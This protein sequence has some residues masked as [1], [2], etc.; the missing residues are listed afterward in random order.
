[1]EVDVV[2]S[3]SKAIEIS[4]ETKVI[5]SLKTPDSALSTTSENSVQNKVITEELNKKVNKT[6]IATING[7]PLT[8]GGNIVIE[9]SGGSYDDTELKEQVA[10]LAEKTEKAEFLTEFYESIEDVEGRSEITLDSESRVIAFRDAEGTKV[11]ANLKVSHSFELADKAMQ[12]FHKALKESGF[13]VETPVDWSSEKTIKL[14]IPRSCAKV[15]IISVTGLAT[16]KTDNKVCILQYWDKD[17]NYFKKYVVLNA[18]G[19][20]SMSYIEK[21][22]GIDVFNDEAC[23]ESCDIIFGNWVAQDSFHLKCYYIDVFRGISNVGYNFSEEVI[24]FMNSRNNRLVL[25]DSSI[26]SS[27]S[28]G[29]FSIDFGDGALCHPDGFPFELYVNGEYYGL[30]AWNLKKHRK[31]YS[32]SKSDYS[33][34]LLDGTLGQKFF[35]GEIDWTAFELRNPKELVTMTGEEYDGENPSELMDETSSAYDANNPVHVNTA[36]AKALVV[37]QSQAPNLISALADT[38]TVEAQALFEQYYDK[39]AVICYFL[40][41]N[42]VFHYDGF[43]K[44]WIWTIYDQIAAPSF[45]DMDSIFGRH[46]NGTQVVSTSLTGILGNEEWHPTR[47]ALRLYWQEIKDTYKALRDAGIISVDNV[48]NHVKKWMDRVGLDAYAS[49][50]EKWDNIP[51]YRAEKTIEDGTAD[52]GFFDSSKRI[53]KWLVERL[54]K[55]DS[56]FAYGA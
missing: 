28:T 7:Q 43:N 19:T 51:S 4:F 16:T 45:Y 21:N 41:S 17:G 24:R 44:N 35:T 18:Q 54:V 36:K 26:T 30:F 40:V 55:L 6:D 42:V 25:D 2:V 15:N 52:G 22:Q 29:D 9:G 34:L 11:E 31:N 33:A 12:K 23:E 27:N 3:G 53:E 5:G 20:S 37:R 8:E 48:M 38:N 47:L 14:P 1:M 49:N 32:M 39:K 13:N 46:W 56:Y 50:I 10:D